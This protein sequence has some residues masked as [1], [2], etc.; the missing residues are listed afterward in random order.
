[1]RSGGGSPRRSGSPTGRATE[2]RR[3]ACSTGSGSCIDRRP[4]GAGRRLAGRDRREAAPAGSFWAAPALGALLFGR[5][6]VQPAPQ[7]LGPQAHADGPDGE[8][9]GQ[10]LLDRDSG[11]VTRDRCE[12]SDH[13]HH[14]AGWA[15]RSGAASCIRPFTV[16]NR[17]P[18]RPRRTA[19]ISPMIEIAVSAAVRAPISS[20]I[21]ADRR[22]RS[23]LVTPS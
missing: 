18:S 16:I 21:G 13:V 1:A 3:P 7:P 10:R 11:H 20:P 2:G 23:S 8:Q 14:P 22:P 19:V 9:A 17:P 15:S 6:P 12:E 5:A 4:T